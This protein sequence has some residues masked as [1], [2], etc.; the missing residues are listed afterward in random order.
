MARSG[1]KSKYW[2]GTSSPSTLPFLPL[3][4]FP[5]PLFPIP[6][7]FPSPPKSPTQ[8]KFSKKSGG[9]QQMQI[10]RIFKPRRRLVATTLFP[11]V[12]TKTF[13][14]E[15]NVSAS[16]NKN[17]LSFIVAR[18]SLAYGRIDD[19]YTRAIPC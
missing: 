16:E 11:F 19:I 8:P 2:Y 12:C 7:P 6:S 9:P 13:P 14:T 1:K 5:C 17:R 10:C 15:A 3:T 4:L 18:L